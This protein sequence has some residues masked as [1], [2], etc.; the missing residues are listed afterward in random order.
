M[1]TNQPSWHCVANLGDANPFEH[2]GDFVLVDKRGIYTPELWHFDPDINQWSR[3]DIGICYEVKGTMVPQV[4]DNKF[5]MTKPAWFSTDD[6]LREAASTSGMDAY[7]LKNAL[8]SHNPVDRA[9][10]FI[11]LTSHYGF[12]EF[13]Q[14]PEKIKGSKTLCAKFL[15]QAEAS[16]KWKDGIQ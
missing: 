16:S 1:K 15:R 8:C 6:K 11:A 2:G 5:H 14:Y 9:Q 10:G 13:D 4:S 3:F 12:Y 7:A